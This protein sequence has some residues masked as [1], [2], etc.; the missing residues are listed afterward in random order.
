MVPLVHCDAAGV[1]LE[2]RQNL[3]ALRNSEWKSGK[4]PC[5]SCSDHDTDFLMDVGLREL[6][7]LSQGF[8]MATIAMAKESA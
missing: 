8:D 3:L 1:K 2:Q 5:S 6:Q 4:M 7:R